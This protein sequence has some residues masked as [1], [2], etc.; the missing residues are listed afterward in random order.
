MSKPVL[1]V[2][3][4]P[5]PAPAHAIREISAPAQVDCPPLPLESFL[6]QLRGQSPVAAM[7]AGGGRYFAGSGMREDLRQAAWGQSPLS[8]FMGAGNSEEVFSPA[9]FRVAEGV[10]EY[11]AVNISASHRDTRKEAACVPIGHDDA[12]RLL[13]KDFTSEA[14]LILASICTR[15]VFTFKLRYNVHALQLHINQ[16]ARLFGQ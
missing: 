1:R 13:A 9:A 6:R 2:D 14:R 10:S 8:A 5:K 16:K 12:S 7:N 3:D 4:T 15:G 11:S